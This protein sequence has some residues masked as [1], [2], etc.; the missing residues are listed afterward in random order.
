M[1]EYGNIPTT[2]TS[3]KIH[4]RYGARDLIIRPTCRPP[5]LSVATNTVMKFLYYDTVDITVI[6]L[7]LI[8]CDNLNLSPLNV[9]NFF[10]SLKKFY[11]TIAS[12]T[13]AI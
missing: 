11:G 7:S 10:K 4:I 12:T 1:Y 2:F 13:V 3:L 8:M 9:S 5:V 6:F